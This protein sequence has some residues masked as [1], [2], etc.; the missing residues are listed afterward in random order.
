MAKKTWPA[1]WGSRRSQKA[2][3]GPIAR[4]LMRPVDELVAAFGVS[5]SDAARGSDT[6]MMER[7]KTI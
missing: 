2:S 1:N 6:A 5:K 3:K 4:R 7:A